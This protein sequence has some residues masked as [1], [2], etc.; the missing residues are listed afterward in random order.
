MELIN[1][2]CCRDKPQPEEVLTRV[3]LRRGQDPNVQ[4]NKLGEWL[5][6]QNLLCY[7]ILETR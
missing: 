7:P 5:K 3:G 4:E 2:S 1:Y 6:R